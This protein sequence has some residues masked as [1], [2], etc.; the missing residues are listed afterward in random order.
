MIRHTV[1]VCPADQSL[2]VRGLAAKAL[3]NGKDHAA[4]AVLALTKCLEDPDEYVRRGSSEAL[5]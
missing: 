2:E 4:E 3:G 5:A 1:R